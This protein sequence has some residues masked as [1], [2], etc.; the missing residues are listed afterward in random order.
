MN[1]KKTLLICA[2]VLLMAAM[3]LIAIYSTEPTA[4]RTSSSK[5]T[6]MLVEVTPVEFGTF[7]PLPEGS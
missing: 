1:W 6:A 3:S 2:T 4:Q 5:Q 7:R